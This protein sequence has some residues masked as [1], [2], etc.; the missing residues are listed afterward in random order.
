MVKSYIG[1]NTNLRTK[2]KSNFEKD[3]F[4]LMNNSVFDKSMENVRNRI[5]IKLC[6]NEKKLEKL[7]SRPN[8][9]SRTTLTA[10]VAAIHMKKTKTVLNKPI[11]IGMCMGVKLGG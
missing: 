9:E 5:D 6:S 7:I 4:K 11:Y 8:F 2:D 10:T 1:F 3:F